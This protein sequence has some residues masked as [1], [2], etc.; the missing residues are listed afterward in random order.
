MNKFAKIAITILLLA[1]A[2]GLIIIKEEGGTEQSE[3][4]LAPGVEQSGGLPKM[5]DLGADKCIPC[6]KMAPIL[7]E[8]RTEYRG[9]L[10][11]E[12]IDVW[13]NPEAGREYGISL[14]PTQIFYDAAG[15]ELT[16]HTGF[17]GKEE[18]LGTF[19]RSGVKLERPKRR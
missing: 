18:I 14:I 11:I 6:K 5:I 7:K 17:M 13:K 12:F 8:I 16:R 4:A 1:A 3:S 9:A 2:A 15:K 10:E 19:K